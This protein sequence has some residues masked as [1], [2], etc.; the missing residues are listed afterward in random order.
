MS[1]PGQGPRATAEALERYA[2]FFNESAH[3]KAFGLRLSFPGGTSV[4]VDLDP[5]QRG[6]RGG[7]G[8]AAV[9]GGVLAAIFDLA[10][11]CT[12]A[13]IDPTRRSATAQLSMSFM[14]PVMGDRLR[15]V[16]RIDQAG[17]TTVFSSASI[18]DE[19]DVECCRCQGLSKL[20]NLPWEPW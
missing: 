6:H 16:A 12:P 2:T 7:L 19:Q 9:N 15:A 20:S 10:I 11:G 4:Q 13:L 3:I 18:L 5:I 17:K 14:R 1:H 8:T